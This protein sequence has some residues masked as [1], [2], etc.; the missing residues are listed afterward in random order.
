M[1]NSRSLS[2]SLSPHADSDH[3]VEVDSS[4]DYACPEGLVFSHNHVLEP[5]VR[6]ECGEDGDVEA[7]EAD[8]W[9]TCIDR[10]C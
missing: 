9:P 3:R 4:A 1:G 6:L 7:A 5:S 8:A 10:K 2:L